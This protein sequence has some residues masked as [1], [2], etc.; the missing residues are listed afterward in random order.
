[1]ATISQIRGALLEEAVLFLLAKVGYKIVRNKTDSIDPS[2]LKNGPSGLEISGRGS[3]HQ[4]DAMAEQHQTA[5]FTF[6]LRLLVE[7]KCY[8]NQ[9]V[10]ISV[11]RNSVGVHKDVSEN[12]FTKDSKKSGLAPVRFNYQSAIFSSS[13]YT[14]PAIEYAVAHQIFLIEY[15]RIPLIEPVISSI[16][17]LETNSITHLGYQKISD[18]RECFSKSLGDSIPTN[19]FRYFTVDGINAIE[20]AVSSILEIRG[21]YFGMLQ[22]RWPLH[23][24][25]RNPLPERIFENDIVKCRVQ[26]NRNGNWRFTPSSVSEGS[27]YWFEL[28]FYLPPQLAKLMVSKWGNAQQIADMKTQHF[29]FIS[30]SGRIGNIWRTV[31]LELDEDWLLRYLSENSD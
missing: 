13:G 28:S 9:H 19:I 25:T 21:S 1:L 18:L 26:G 30:M 6:P 27:E 17:S 5:A 2:D 29:S 20:S 8:L 31:K 22:G 15:K 7:A 11:V 4:I 24:L 23:L 10:G 14:K 3:L 12:Y 16:L